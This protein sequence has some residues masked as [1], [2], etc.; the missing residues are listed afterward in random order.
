MTKNLGGLGHSAVLRTLPLTGSLNRWI[1]GSFMLAQICPNGQTSHIPE[2]LCDMP[3][4]NKEEI[5]NV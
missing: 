1:C 3:Q 5:K 4:N 2:T